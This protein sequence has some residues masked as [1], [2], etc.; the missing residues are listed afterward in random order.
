MRPLIA[1]QM[2]EGT[3][4][5]VSDPFSCFRVFLYASGSRFL[6]SFFPFS[7]QLVEQRPIVDHCIAQV[8]GITVPSMMT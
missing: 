8:F 7:D 1:R 3:S 4:E 5:R 6:V 2:R